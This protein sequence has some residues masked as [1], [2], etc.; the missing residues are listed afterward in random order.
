MPF[1]GAN[2]LLRWL[3]FQKRKPLNRRS[4]MNGRLNSFQF[5]TITSTDARSR[6][7]EIQAVC[8]GIRS[9]SGQHLDAGRSVRHGWYQITNAMSDLVAYIDGGSFGNPGPSGIGVVISGSADGTIRIARWIGQQDNNVAEYVAL[10]EALQCALLLKAKALRVFSDSEVMV[11]QMTGE[12]SCR[13]PRLYSLNWICRKVARSLD[14]SI[15][16]VRREN[17]T[18]ANGLASSAAHSAQ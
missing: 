7:Q 13:S 16:H 2:G 11:K 4:L 8:A 18:E 14:F 12:Y 9:E 3:K 10:L 6:G 5:S 17:N 1:F 15:S